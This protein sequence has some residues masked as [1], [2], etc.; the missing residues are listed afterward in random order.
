MIQNTFRIIAGAFKM[1][2]RDRLTHNSF[3]FVL[4]IQPVL[5][6][7][8]TV[9]L[10][11]FAGQQ[12]LS[13][14]G[15]IGAGMIGVWNAN[16]WSSGFIVDSE[17][18]SNTLELILASPS[19]IELVLFGKSLTNALASGL[20]IVVTFLTGVLVFQVTIDIA[21]PGL[22]IASLA[23]AIFAMTCLGLLIGTLFMLTRA[24]GGMAQV[25]NYP[26][27]IL[28]GLTF[29]ITTLPLWTRP[30]SFGLVTTW[31]NDTLAQT[32]NSG[33]APLSQNVAGNLLWMF[34]LAIG[35]LAVAHFLFLRIEG[36]VRRMGGL[37][38]V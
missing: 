28:S 1:Q 13:V 36:L 8:L 27:F 21:R 35:Y 37:D 7:L 26:I 33:V 22:F 4:F 24:A 19:S 15:I 11:R 32:V 10:Y 2:T 6:T 14:Y 25:L 16:L 3:Q 9:G 12:D 34:A 31:A 5:F 23:L 17:R 20:S 29:P 38:K 18:R 30:F